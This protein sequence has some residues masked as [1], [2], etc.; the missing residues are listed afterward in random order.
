MK[1]KIYLL[2]MLLIPI[3]SI[4]AVTTFYVDPSSLN[5][6]D[7]N[8]G[9]SAT[10]PWLTLNPQK[11]VNDCVVIL[12]SGTHT[13]LETANVRANVT[14]QGA[15]KSDVIIEGLSED[16]IA[17]GS[18][19][20]RFFNLTGSNTLTIK[21]ITIRNFAT[22]ESIWGGMFQV[23]SNST[24]NLENVDI[25][26]A[27]LPGTGGAAISSNGTLNCTN[28]LFERCLSSQGA[29][30]TIQ[31]KG[32][33]SFENVTFKNNSTI[34]GNHIYKMGGA[35]KIQS[36]TANI[37]MN[38]CYFD[39]NT[40]SD[41]GANPSSFQ[42]MGGA[43]GLRLV[44]GCDVKL[45]ITNSTFNNNYSYGSG[46]AIVIDRVA[47]LTTNGNINLLFTNNTFVRNNTQNTHGTAFLF[48]N[49]DSSAVKGSMSFVNNTF[50]QNGPTVPTSNK[51]S[52]FI[53]DLAVDFCFINNIVCDQ[54][55]NA[56]EDKYYGWGLVFTTI[57]PTNFT[58]V[59]FK[60]NLFDGVGGN[61]ADVNDQ[62]L[63][64]DNQ[65]GRN[66]VFM[67]DTELT[68]PATGVPYLK[69]NDASSIAIDKGTNEWLLGVNNLVPSLDT[70]GAAVVGGTK[71][72]GAYEF[73]GV[74]KVMNLIDNSKSLAYPNPFKDVL[75]L[76]EQAASVS[77]L[78]ITG[79][80][81]ILN[82]NVSSINTTNL[83]E[84]IYFLRIVNNDGKVSALKMMK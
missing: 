47:S 8:D 58:S 25:T 15:S 62:I 39:S 6:S 50:F 29:A 4:Q 74:T 44:E 35:I 54:I 75:Y 42:C 78:D 77:L 48:T 28:V 73:G 31:D 53:Y 13:V 34:D 64:S 9:T 21:D 26:N 60:G 71:D 70:R 81:M 14:L 2:L 82:S 30:I 61:H 33:A 45:A 59:K 11:W 41:D 69:I 40:C 17:R 76:S 84:G 16:D 43:I 38:H 10:A 7:L 52:L 5:A 22:T 46:G 63:G 72:A 65:F 55:Y 37:S 79:K 51:S 19:S 83:Q 24:L 32:I 18:T 67:L 1:K 80:T 20:P 36:L 66:N 68:F 27:L 56:A 3:L 49:W 57:S 12:S 23:E